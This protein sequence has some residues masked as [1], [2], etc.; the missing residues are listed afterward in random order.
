MISPEDF[1]YITSIY[2]NDCYTYQDFNIDLIK[3]Q[4]FSHLILTGKNGSG[5]ST[6]LSQINEHISTMRKNGEDLLRKAVGIRLNIES[7]NN[8]EDLKTKYV[9]VL[10]DW[11]KEINEFERIIP[12]YSNK[13]DPTLFILKKEYVY[14]YLLP[15][16]DSKVNKVETPT[17]QESFENQIEQSDTKGFFIKN[18]KQFLVNKKVN[19]AFAQIKHHNSEIANTDVF[20]N[21]I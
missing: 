13:I 14:S 16:R 10:K 1:P 7:S 4:P 11:E 20:F 9:G 3:H 19:Q 18:F 17:K 2:V 8:S 15:F 6:I 21:K 5:K 12:T